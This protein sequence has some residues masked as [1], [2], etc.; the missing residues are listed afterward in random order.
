[1]VSV[2]VADPYVTIAEPTFVARF[3]LDPQR[4]TTESVANVD[5]FVDLLDGSS[6]AL[7][8]FAA[9]EACRLLARWEETGEAARGCDVLAVDQLIV[10]EP[11][12]RAMVTVI[13]ELVRTGEITRVGARCAAP[14]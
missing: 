13:R 12:V 10:A 1:M 5:V 3:L 8:V 6:W 11:G 7:T 14:G 2:G 9:D 4:D